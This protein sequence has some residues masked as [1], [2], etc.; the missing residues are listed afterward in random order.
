M[1]WRYRS[2]S[3]IVPEANQRS[4]D[5][6]QRYDIGNGLQELVA[7]GGRGLGSLKIYLRLVARR[8]GATVRLR[9]PVVIDRPVKS[10]QIIA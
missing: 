6:Y 8:W 9:V 7:C 3:P 2:D 1:T 10:L 4:Q 5:M